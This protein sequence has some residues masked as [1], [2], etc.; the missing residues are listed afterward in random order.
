M[1]FN[2]EFDVIYI[3]YSDKIY[4]Y[5]YLQ[6]QNPY[7]A[8]DI[9]A[10]VFLRA[11]KNW[12]KI[13][14]DFIQALLFKIAKNILIDYWRKQKYK[15]EFSLETKMEEGFDASYDEDL[16]E[17]IHKDDS[18]KEVQRALSQLPSNLRDVVILRFIEELSAKEAADILNITEGN[19]R[20]LQYRALA[21]LKEVFKS[22]R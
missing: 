12:E 9:T 5:L 16:I 17:K 13:K 6:T 2:E 8:E 4:R 15:K 3:R 18:I 1:H 7:L 10:E 22:D 11:W 21:K 19:V 14:H 20:V